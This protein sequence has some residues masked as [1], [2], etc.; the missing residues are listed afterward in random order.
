MFVAITIVQIL[1]ILTGLFCLRQHGPAILYIILLLILLAFIN[2]NIIVIYSMKWWHIKRNVFYNLFSLLEISAW[3]F[4][5]YTIF[6]G[7]TTAR[8]M[9]VFSWLAI[10]AYSCIELFLTHEINSFHTNSYACFCI[11]SLVSACAYIMAVNHKDYHR[12]SN[13]PAFWLCAAAVC[14]NCI[15]FINLTTMMDPGYWD[16][17]RAKQIFHIL[18][19][20]AVIIYHVFICIAFLT[21]YYRLRMTSTP[22][23]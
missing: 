4:I 21:S 13:D 2:E 12:L 1:I 6:R 10:M 8:A 3:C 20:I 5:Y 23:L 18:Q 19:S 15:F 11:F 17:P 14:F 16:H 22:A 9:I 7:R